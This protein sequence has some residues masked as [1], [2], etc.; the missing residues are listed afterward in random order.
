MSLEVIIIPQKFRCPVCHRD[1]STMAE[2][3]ECLNT[4]I[5]ILPI[6]TIFAKQFNNI[7]FC[8]GSNKDAIDRHYYNPSLWACRDN[9]YGDS[10]GDQFCCSG[11]VNLKHL[12]PPN[13]SHPT[14][15]RMVDY[16]NSKNIKPII[17]ST[18]K[19]RI[20]AIN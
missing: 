4:K 9:G 19:N 2:A 1:Y 16:L 11:G 3:Q 10:L 8:V 7:T 12:D 5:E 15:I 17:F 20:L 6:G 13:Q 18:L 14:F